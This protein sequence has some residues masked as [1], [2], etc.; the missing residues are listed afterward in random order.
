MRVG[1]QGKKV[2]ME[3][4]DPVH[5]TFLVDVSGSMRSDDKI[6]LVKKSLIMLTEE[7][8]DG[9]TVAIAT[10]AGSTRRATRRCRSRS[11]STPRRASR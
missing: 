1:V 8:D 10:Y 2:S 3:E 9:D 4:R 7:L 11:R 6:E 5:L